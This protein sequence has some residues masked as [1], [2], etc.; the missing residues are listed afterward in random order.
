L[1]AATCRACKRLNN[2]R[3]VKAE[4]IQALNIAVDYL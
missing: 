2:G 1:S 4:V 3:P